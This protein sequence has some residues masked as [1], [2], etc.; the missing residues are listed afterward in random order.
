MLEAIWLADENNNCQ[1]ETEL[2]LSFR[3]SKVHIEVIQSSLTFSV[4]K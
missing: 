2:D 3:F 1:S 4:Q